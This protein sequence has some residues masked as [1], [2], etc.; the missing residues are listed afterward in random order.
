MMNLYP[1]VKPQIT[2]KLYRETHNPW[3]QDNSTF[4]G[5]LP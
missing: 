1:E 2:Y 5:N 4:I 3:G